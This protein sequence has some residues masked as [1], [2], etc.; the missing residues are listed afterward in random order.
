MINEPGK[1]HLIDELA[2]IA[3]MSRRHLSRQ[4]KLATGIS[5]AQYQAQTLLEHARL[6]L[7][8]PDLSVEI[9]AERGVSTMRAIC[10]ACGSKPLELAR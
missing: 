8:N 5:I 1:R 10:A 4:F 2:T 3:S 6:L 9:V 7:S